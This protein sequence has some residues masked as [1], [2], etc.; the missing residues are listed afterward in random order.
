MIAMLILVAI[1]VVIFISNGKRTA[2]F[3][4]LENEIF[5]TEYGVSGMV[6]DRKEKF[7]DAYTKSNIIGTCLCI[8]SLI[9]LFAGAVINEN[10]DLLLVFMLSLMFVI[11]GIGVIFFVSRGIIW[12]SFEKL[13]QE[14]EYSKR[15]KENKTVA[16][17]LSTAFWM[18]TTAIFLA[19]SFIT[20][21]WGRS[22]IIWPVAGVLYPA[23]T[24]LC[25]MVSKK[26]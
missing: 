10:N 11:A 25:S 26:K 1:A 3:E 15:R 14:G 8:F 21:D 20:S 24:A 12:A 23:V 22:W 17:P 18:I 2:E 9:P 7:K 19:Y 16:S 6:K 5:E 13:L 4:Y